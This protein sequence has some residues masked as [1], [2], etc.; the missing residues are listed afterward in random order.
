MRITG[1]DKGCKYG[2]TRGTTKTR[3]VATSKIQT[4]TGKGHETENARA[5]RGYAS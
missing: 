3:E 4:K 2:N 5:R 1:E